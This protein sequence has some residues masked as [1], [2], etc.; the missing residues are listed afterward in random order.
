MSTR[1]DR[2]G[3]AERGGRNLVRCARVEDADWMTKMRNL[4]TKAF[5]DNFQHAG[6]IF[7]LVHEFGGIR[8]ESDYV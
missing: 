5:I 1:I 3:N 2:P 7:V 4:V 6:R 8:L